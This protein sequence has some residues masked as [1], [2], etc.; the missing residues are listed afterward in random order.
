MNAKWF[1]DKLPSQHI[2][3]IYDALL[4]GIRVE[5]YSYF[6]CETTNRYMVLRKKERKKD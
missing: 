4:A 5:R 6:V 1:M 2:F 3:S